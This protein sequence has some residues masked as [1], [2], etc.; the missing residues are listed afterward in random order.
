MCRGFGGCGP[1]GGV[2]F[3]GAVVL[4]VELDA[5]I[6]VG[7]DVEGLLGD[8]K[9]G[10]LGGGEDMTAVDYQLTSISRKFSGGP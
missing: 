10:K 3:V 6:G 4:V 7:E 9:L 2:R 5:G 8:V 1:G